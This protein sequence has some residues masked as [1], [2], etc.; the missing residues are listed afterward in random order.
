MKGYNNDYGGGD[1]SV[2]SDGPINEVDYNSAGS[3]SVKTVDSVNI[4]A[5]AHS[6]PMKGTPNSVTQ[7]YRNGN[8][9]TERYFDENGNAYLDI[10]YTDHGNPVT[11]PIV[12]HEHDI[13]HDKNGKI[14]RGRAKGINK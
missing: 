12:P 7:V 5:D 14:N 1:G 3:K 4:E 6:V 10:D 13:T 2:A 11:H 8:K 9:V